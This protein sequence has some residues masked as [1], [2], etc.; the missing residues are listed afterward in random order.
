VDPEVQNF[1]QVMAILVP[2]IVVLIASGVIGHRYVV[3]TERGSAPR[4]S[5]IDDER[6]TRLE[7]AVEAV[8]IEV[9]R[10]SE[11]Q[12]FVTRVLAERNGALEPLRGAER[13]ITPH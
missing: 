7:Q 13:A 8:A 1:A 6:F 4:P 10:I 3:R 12:R 9:E 2:S 5:K 11:G